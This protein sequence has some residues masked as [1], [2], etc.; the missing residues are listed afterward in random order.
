MYLLKG[1][2]IVIF[3]SIKWAENVTERAKVIWYCTCLN[4]RN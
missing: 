4:A 3:I 2:A 1:G